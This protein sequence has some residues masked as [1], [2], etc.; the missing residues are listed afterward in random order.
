M[1]I[2]TLKLMEFFRLALRDQK[3]AIELLERTSS[4]EERKTMVNYTTLGHTLLHICAL[5]DDY[6]FVRVLHRHGAIFKFD[7]FGTT[8]GMIATRSSAWNVLRVFF[9]LKYIVDLTDCDDYIRI[10]MRHN[11]TEFLERCVMKKLEQLLNG[12]NR[13]MVNYLSNALFEG[14]RYNS[15]RSLS[16]FINLIKMTIEDKWQKVIFTSVFCCACSL[17]TLNIKAFS[18]LLNSGAPSL[19]QIS[20]SHSSS[21]TPFEAVFDVRRND[22]HDPIS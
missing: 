17:N 1:D 2:L 8:P 20:T 21:Y 5:T 18:L 3:S 13:T 10:F 4:A 11:V 22:N 15:L 6:N 19:M 7:T 9:E 14:V 16:L 12:D